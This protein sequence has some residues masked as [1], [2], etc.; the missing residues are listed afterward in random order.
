[1]YKVL[2]TLA[3]TTF[4]IAIVIPTAIVALGSFK[5]DVEVYSKPLALPTNWSFRNYNRLISDG[6]I[7]TNFKNSVIVTS[8]SVV[9][10][11]ILASMAAFAISRM[12]NVTGRVLF[13]LFALGLAIPGQVNIIPIYLLFQRLHLTNSL[14]GLVLINIATTLPISIFILTSFFREL[15]KEMFEVSAIDGAGPFQIYRSIALPLSRPAMGA[16]SI[17]LFVISWNDLLYPLLLVT[18][19]DKKTLPLALLDYRGEY[20]TSFSMIFTAVMVAS[21]P[22]VVMYLFMQRSFIAG[23]TA[24]AV[25]G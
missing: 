19:S 10:T 25:K 2:R 18:Q 16:T 11:L 21:I 6:G 9:L 12:T 17:F 20:A 13:G 23:L 14:L 5:S 15:P 4:A 3:L 8:F 22:M 24:G 7:F 1:M